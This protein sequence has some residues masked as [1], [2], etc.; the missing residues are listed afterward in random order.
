L[1]QGSEERTKPREGLKASQALILRNI[2]VLR[3]ARELMSPVR[4]AA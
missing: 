1:G 2:K 4:N 3:G